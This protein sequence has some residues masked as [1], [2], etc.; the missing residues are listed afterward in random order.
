MRQKLHL[1]AAA[2]GLYA[3]LCFAAWL[4]QD[5]LVF[6]P[7]GPPVRDPRSV[8]LAF[9]ALRPRTADGL[10]LDAWWIPAA[11]PRGAVIVSHGNAGSIEGRLH[12]AHAFHALGLGVL[13]YDYRGYGRSAGR[14]SE[15]GLYLDAE[16]AWQVLVEQ[17]GVAPERLLIYGESL[18]GAVAVEL[19]ARRPAAGLILESSFSSLPAV[20]ARAYPYLPVRLLARSRFDSLAKIGA[21]ALPVLVIH[22]PE[23]E[24]VPFAHGEAL[25]AAAG[26]STRRVQSSGG[27]N[28][29]GFP[30]REELVREVGA[31]VDACLAAA[32]GAR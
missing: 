2:L 20:G 9:E 3:L 18:G 32:E 8:G 22:S 7:G 6:Y 12:I 29:G 26:G 11:E 15:R 19:A 25:R 10:E 30:M 23:D 5:R 1:I 24:V 31:F 14:P 13:L 17:L 21:L 28:A 16:A 27:H 4:F